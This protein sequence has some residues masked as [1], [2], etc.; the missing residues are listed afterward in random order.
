MALTTPQQFRASVDDRL[1]R[2]ARSQGRPL[3][4]IRTLLVMERFLARMVATEPDAFLLKGGLALELRLAR[5]RTTRD[6]DVLARGSKDHAVHLVEQ[7]AA[8]RPSPDDHLDFDVKPNPSDPEIDG[9]GVRYHGIRFR[10]TP[11]I[12]SRPFGD[13]FGVD[14]ALADA[15]VGEPEVLAGSDFFE[16]Y[17]LA[18]LR[19]PVYPLPS[20]IAEKVH[21]YTLPRI[22]PNSRLKDLVDLAL[23]TEVEGHDAA[24]L[25]EA[26]HRT[27]RFRASHHVPEQLPGPPE[28]WTDRYRRVRD[29]ERLP[30]ATTEQLV[31]AAGEL[32]NPVFKGVRGRWSPSA[33]A[34]TP[35]A[36]SYSV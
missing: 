22:G 20:H 3:N 11:T 30:W 12:A 19:V 8:R 28:E 24:M 6:V 29:E 1:R 10:V 31:E 26:I 34:W 23:L 13:P 18:R 16:R 25:R 33:R 7:A 32:L 27:F 14:V 9:T 17:G 35:H 4:R 36:D 21:A 5:A 15:V 2:A